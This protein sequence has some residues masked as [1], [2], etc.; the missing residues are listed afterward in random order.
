MSTG[1]TV[2]DASVAAFTEFK[3]QSNSTKFLIF[4]IE[5]PSIVTEHSSESADFNE[6]MTLL[7]T[8]DCRYA[9]YKMDFTTTDGRPN[10]KIASI[11]WSPDSSSVKPKMVYAGSKDALTRVLVGVS[12]KITATDASEL[13]A[14][15]VQDA[16][17]K[18]N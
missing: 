13:T 6:F 2:S 3:K 11:A 18:F 17:R 4:K 8:N 16:C 14:E 5:G 12:V 9:V 7:P 10:T 15:I 1:V